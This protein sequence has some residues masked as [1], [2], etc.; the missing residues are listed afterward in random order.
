M[1]IFAP[2]PAPPGTSGPTYGRFRFIA[3]KVTK[4]NCVFR[5]QRAEGLPAG[6][7]RYHML[8]PIGTLGDVESALAKLA[9]KP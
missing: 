1:G 4:W 5:I 9:R 6:E 7:Y 3:E 2:D 8:A